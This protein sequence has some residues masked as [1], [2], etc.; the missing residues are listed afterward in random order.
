MFDLRPLRPFVGAPAM[1]SNPAMSTLIHGYDI[2]VIVPES[3][4]STRIR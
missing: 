4:P 3:T 1:A 2:V